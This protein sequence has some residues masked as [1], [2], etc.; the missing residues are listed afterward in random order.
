MIRVAI[1][2]RESDEDKQE[3]SNEVQRKVCLAFLQEDWEVTNIYEDKSTGLDINRPA[4]RQM[5][6][7]DKDQWDIILAR[8]RKRL[9]RDV[10]NARRFIK[11]MMKYGKQAWSVK[12]GHLTSKKNAAEWFTELMMQGMGEFESRQISERTIPGMEHAKERGVH[13]GRPPTGMWWNREKMGLE[14]T[15]WMLSIVRGERPPYPKGKK[16]G[17]VPS[18]A[19]IQTVLRNY[20]KWKAGTLKV[21]REETEAGSHSKF[22]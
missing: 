16:K 11:K 19:V 15:E 6:D 4:Y 22:A 10:D 1:Y 13:V 18:F 17:Q 12:E 3:Q 5:I 20:R 14:P 8:S 7:D 9:H 21:N 2:L